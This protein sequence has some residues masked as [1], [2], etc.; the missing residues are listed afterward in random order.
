MVGDQ[1]DPQ[2]LQRR[3]AL[4]F[5]HVNAVEYQTVIRGWS[6][7]GRESGCN[8]GGVGAGRQRAGDVG[9]I[10]PFHRFGR[11]RAHGGVQ[12]THV[13]M[14]VRVDAIGE[15][16]H[17]GLGK[18]IDPDGG[19]GEAGVAV[20][21]QREHLAPPAVAG[22]N[23]PAKS[24]AGEHPL[25]GLH[26]RHHLDRVGSQNP[27]ALEFALVHH[28]AREAGQ[29]RGGAEHSRVPGHPPHAARGRVMHDAAQRTFG[30]G[31]AGSQLAA[32]QVTG[33]MHFEG[34]VDRLRHI[35]FQRGV[36]DAL[37]DLA[38]QN[39]VNIAVAKGRAGD[40]VGGFLA[41]E[42][43]GRGGSI[44][45]AAQAG[46]QAGG[47]GEQLADGDLIFPIALELRDVFLDPCIEPH[48]VP[49]DQPHDAWRGGHHLGQRGQIENGV[50]GHGF[51]PG[52]DRPLSVGSMVN[53]P[54]S[55]HPKHRSRQTLLGDGVG[56]GPVQL[57]QFVGVENRL[58]PY[59]GLGGRSERREQNQGQQ[60]HGGNIR[61]L[62]PCLEMLCRGTVRRD[63]AHVRQILVHRRAKRFHA[64]AASFDKSAPFSSSHWGGR[65]W[66]PRAAQAA[67]ADGPGL[68]AQGRSWAPTTDKELPSSFRPT[69]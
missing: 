36:R 33:F 2:A 13:A 57:G 55:F 29:I 52:H 42:S 23:V 22:V 35:G 68:P 47:V 49:F 6:V 11:Q 5:Q 67:C 66:L 61:E 18:G 20:R 69:A 40:R 31:D 32:G 26:R 46:A 21:A 4:F 10:E 1:P 27:L 39:E 15:K 12:R 53:R 59:F 60:H 14:A 48:E 56:D 7:G 44:H 38:E 17:E 25:G 24:T 51:R 34:T 16:N 28:H 19:A 30:G 37:D 43:D 58:Q 3:E 54:V 64:L 63:P 50:L 9:E 41:S 45:S 62:R 8:C 65:G